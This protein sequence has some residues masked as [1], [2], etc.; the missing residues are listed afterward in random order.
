MKL[1]GR[2]ASSRLVDCRDN[3]EIVS[4][5]ECVFSL[6]SVVSLCLPENCIKFQN[7]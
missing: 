6:R 7:A 4:E 2:L 5:A 3:G 1:L